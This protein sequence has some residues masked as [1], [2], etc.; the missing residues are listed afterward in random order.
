[1]KHFR[2]SSTNEKTPSDL[3]G[4]DHACM[5]FLDSGRVMVMPRGGKRADKGKENRRR[6]FGTHEN[7]LWKR[8]MRKEVDK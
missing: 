8:G 4:R 6:A 7:A 1:M 2:I 3:H 5:G